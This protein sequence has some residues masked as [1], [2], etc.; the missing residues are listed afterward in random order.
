[1]PSL[2]KKK[3]GRNSTKGAIVKPQ[4]PR[5][6]PKKQPLNVSLDDK[7]HD[8]CVE[9]PLAIEYPEEPSTLHSIAMACENTSMAKEDSRREQEISNQPASINSTAS[10]RRR[11]GSN[12]RTGGQTC[13]SGLPLLTLDTNGEP[14]SIA[15]SRTSRSYALIPI[16]SSDNDAALMQTIPRDVALPRMILCL[17]H[18]GKVAWDIKWRPRDFS[19]CESRHRM[20][21]LAVL[22]GSG[23][24]EV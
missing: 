16:K 21:Y 9:Q 8:E 18:N 5:G 15:S 11:L 10:K 19:C 24:L 14:S 1:M 13:D 6:R 23:A 20:G 7:N 12:A 3:S 17:A 22:L 2:V 4:R